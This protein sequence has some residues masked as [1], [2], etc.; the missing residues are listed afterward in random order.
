MIVLLKS[1]LM[2]T[3]R[4]ST[5]TVFLSLC[6]FCIGALLSTPMH[7]QLW[8]MLTKPQITVNLNHPPR[9][10]LNIKR[11]AFGPSHGQC[12]DDILNRLTGTLISGGVEVVDRHQFR[13][14][15][16][17]KHFS[18]GG[19]I[20]QQSALRMGKLLGP[21]ALIF[22]KIS[23]CDSEQ[24]RD[25]TE[26]K[27]YKGEYVRTENATVKMHIR[28][29]LQTVDLTT[30]R[31]FSASPIIEDAELS[32]HSKDGRPEFPAWES[33]R[34][35]AVDRAAYDAS[36]MFIGWTEQKKL[37][38]FN[39]KDCN[40]S[41]AYSLLKANDFDGVVRQSEANIATCKTWPNVKDSNL[42][43]AYYNA[44]L[45][46]LLVNDHEKAMAYLL[47]SE[48]LKG[49]L[50]VTQTIEQANKAANL[51]AE[52]Q[53]VADKTEAFE[54]EQADI[55]AADQAAQQSAAAASVSNSSSAKSASDSAEDRLKKLDSL[56]K[57]G[58]INK[59]DYEI[60][61]AEILKDF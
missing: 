1:T 28:G 23:Q 37:Y 49:G 16:A 33:V 39:D 2:Q 51:D 4:R 32:N 38:F 48:Q 47:Q 22:V 17:E 9:L 41:V 12:S 60:K 34:D 54:Q 46:Y 6:V 29:T 5:K 56:L 31:I 10:G 35:L 19:Y 8:D 27:N 25:F 14:L 58:L 13:A 15:M 61:K 30:G 7:A 57:K 3:R 50:I 36:T 24:H 11:V 21:T 45:A 55:T 18:M 43:H 59:Q 53:R 42:A 40:L 20:D 52:I 44:G 26:S